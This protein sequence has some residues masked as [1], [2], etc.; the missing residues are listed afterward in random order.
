MSCEGHANHHFE[1]SDVCQWCGHPESEH[2]DDGFW[3]DDRGHPRRV[4]DDGDSP[5]VPPEEQP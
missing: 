2:D 5:P 1:R 4:D 3:P